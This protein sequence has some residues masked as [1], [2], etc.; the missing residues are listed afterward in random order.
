[1]LGTRAHGMPHDE[2]VPVAAVPLAAPCP[3]APFVVWFASSESFNAASKDKAAAEKD[4]VAGDEGADVGKVREAREA[5]HTNKGVSEVDWVSDCWS[6]SGEVDS[7]TMEG[8][9]NAC[10]CCSEAPSSPVSIKGLLVETAGNSS[11]MVVG[12]ALA[13]KAAA[14][15]RGGELLMEVSVSVADAAL[16][17]VEVPLL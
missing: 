8:F 12:F 7:M 6:F 4:C 15:A 1:M 5:S 9:C 16:M 14:L 13:I 3:L 11:S 17:A 2:L 10:G